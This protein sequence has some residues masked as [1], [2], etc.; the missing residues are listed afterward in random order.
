M[1]L[2]CQSILTES[3]HENQKLKIKLQNDRAEFKD[4]FKK[5]LYTQRFLHQAS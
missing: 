5:K 2:S 1:L 3:K 4:K